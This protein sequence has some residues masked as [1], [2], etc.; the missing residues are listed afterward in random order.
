ML[1]DKILLVLILISFIVGLILGEDTRGGG[2]HDYLYHVKYF[3]NFHLNFKETF[4]N[5]GSDQINDNVRNSPI[6]YIFFSLF[7]NLGLDTFGLKIINLFLLLP[8][9]YFLNKCI[10]LKYPNTPLIIKLYFFSLLLLTPTNRT[11]FS[12]PYPLL[13]AL[14]FFIISIYFYLKFEISINE[15]KKMNFAYLNIICLASAAYF[16]P[17]FS[18]FSIYFFFKFYLNYKNSFK[19]LKIIFLN[20][21]LS[22]PAIIF[23]ISKDFYL[24][25]SNVKYVSDIQKYNITN[26][27]II[28]TSIIFIFILPLISNIQKIKEDSIFSNLISYK[29]FF[30]ISFFII[31]IYFFNF[32][33]NVGGGIIFRISNLLFDN[34][35][36]IFLIFGFSLLIFYFLRLFNLNNILL[37]SLLIIYNIQYEIYYKYFDP[38]I[39]LLLFFLI[40]NEEKKFIKIDLIIKKYVLLYIVFLMLNFMKGYID[41]Y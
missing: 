30:L 33:E 18:V 14:A 31:N 39:I 15:N 29:S 7:L 32:S 36:F 35:Y 28:I 41:Y 34:S 2:K 11:L 4:L 10:D 9:F 13:W 27:I 8:I 37:F 23:I 3:E 26:K 24:F 12:C 22:L 16:T 20:I 6:F 1:K 19:T 17:N 5:Y 25:D 40:K 21:F 38:L